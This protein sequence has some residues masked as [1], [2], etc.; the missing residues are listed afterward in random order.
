MN[1]LRETSPAQTQKKILIRDIKIKMASIE[2]EPPLNER[3][4]NFSE[5]RKQ[6][7]KNV[8]GI[9]TL[10]ILCGSFSLY[11]HNLIDRQPNDIDL[12]VDRNDLRIKK[13]IDKN[14]H[15][16]TEHREKTSFSNVVDGFDNVEQFKVKDILLDMFHDTDAKYVEYNGFKVQCPFQVIQ[17][18]LDIYKEVS[19]TKDLR[20]LKLINKRLDVILDSQEEA[21]DFDYLIN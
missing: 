14:K 16:I 13:F 6:Y 5:Y 1:Q 17:K 7:Q 2:T 15:A 11:V 12:L 8:E 4:F 19:R 10:G 21:L 20:D 9:K 18:K 3:R